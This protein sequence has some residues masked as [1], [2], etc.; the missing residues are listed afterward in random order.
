L[1]I[2][3]FDFFLLWYWEAI[4][5]IVRAVYNLLIIIS[6]MF[7]LPVLFKTLLLPYK[8]EN[9]KG[10]VIYAIGIG[11]VLRLIAITVCLIIMLLISLFGLAFLMGWVAVPFLFLFLLFKPI[12]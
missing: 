7:A 10:F 6:D 2:L 11:L 1:G 5:A 12:T 4:L 3:L 8:V 9:R